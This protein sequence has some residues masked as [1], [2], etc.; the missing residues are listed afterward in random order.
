MDDEGTLAL[1]SLEL[2]RGASSLSDAAGLLAGAHPLYQSALYGTLRILGV[3]RDEG[4]LLSVLLG[5]IGLG[6]LARVGDGLWPQTGK[7]LAVALGA[8][9][10]LGLVLDRSIL[11]EGPWLLDLRSSR[12]A[13]SH[14]QVDL[15]RVVCWH[16]GGKPGCRLQAPRRCAHPSDRGL[17][18]SCAAEGCCFPFLLGAAIVLRPGASCGFRKFL[19]TRVICKDRLTEPKMGVAEPAQIVLH[20]M[21]AGLPGYFFSYQIRA[22]VVPRCLNTLPSYS[23]LAVGLMQRLTRCSSP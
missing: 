12:A 1:P 21:L 14:G 16:R 2:I 17:V 22:L 4:R 19:P 9:S 8:T 6:A 3:G 23:R 20:M 15:G 18:Y 7:L 10:F 11:V 13:C 5:L